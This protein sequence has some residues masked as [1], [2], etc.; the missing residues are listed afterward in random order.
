MARS[1]YAGSE[2]GLDRLA[3]GTQVFSKAMRMLLARN[4]LTHEQLVKLSQWCNPWGTTWLSTSQISYLRTGTLKKAGPATLDALGQ[5]NLRVAQAA[6]A[7]SAAIDELPDFGPMPA[8][9]LGLPEEPFYLR[10]PIS[11]EPLDAGGLYMVWIGRLVPESL[12]GDGH[13]S[14]MEARR[15]SANLGRIVQ[16]W[17]RDRRLTIAQALEQALTAYGVVDESRRQRLRSVV[18]GFEVFAGAELS[19]ELPAL[20]AM[21]GALDESDPIGVG[22]VRER[23]YRLPRD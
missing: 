12:E 18:V 19:D 13:I 2:H 21:L 20:G 14:D 1:D 9:N 7:S 4:N 17:A 11:H 6:G 10:H 5:V 15:L 23:L 22:D 3:G 16:A 8:Q